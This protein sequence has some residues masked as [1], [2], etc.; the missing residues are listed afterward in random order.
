MELS[1]EWHEYTYI[2]IYVERWSTKTPI[3]KNINTFRQ[4]EGLPLSESLRILRYN[5]T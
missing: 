5:S 1:A 2:A 4:N 3:I